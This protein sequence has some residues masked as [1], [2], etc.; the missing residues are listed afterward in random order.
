M[1]LSYIW[2]RIIYLYKTSYILLL[3]CFTT[4]NCK[5]Y[6]HSIFGID[7]SIR[8]Y[9]NY[10]HFEPMFFGSISLVEKRIL[11]D[12]DSV[13]P[14]DCCLP[15]DLENPVETINRFVNF[16]KDKELL[17]IQENAFKFAQNFDSKK[18][19]KRLIKNLSEI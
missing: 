10:T 14:E 3:F 6:A 8:G 11:N 17:K 7:A 15:Y 18:V 12:P 5:Y 9:T 4:C 16:N 2:K 13:I 1:N 19:A